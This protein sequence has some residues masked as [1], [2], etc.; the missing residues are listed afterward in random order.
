MNRTFALLFVAAALAGCQANAPTSDPFLRTRVP[1][2]GTGAAVPPGGAYYPNASYP[3]S[4]PSGSGSFPSTTP[5]STPAIP[6]S[7]PVVPPKDKFSPPGGF[8]LQ[9]SSVEP[10]KA[11]PSDA[12]EQ[13]SPPDQRPA[14]TLAIRRPATINPG[15]GLPIRDTAANELTMAAAETPEVIKWT[16]EMLATPTA[17]RA[18][19]QQPLSMPAT[20]TLAV[21]TAAGVAAA[22]ADRSVSAVAFRTTEPAPVVRTVQETAATSGPPRPAGAATIRILEPGSRPSEVALNTPRANKLDDR[23]DDNLDDDAD[24]DDD[25][26]ADADRGQTNLASPTRL[27]PKQL[28][29]AKVATVASPAATTQTPAATGPRYA[30]D[31]AYRWLSGMLEY[32]Q[33]ARQWKLRYIPIDG[34]TDQYGGSMILADSPSLQDF[35]PGD[36]VSIHGTISAKQPATRGF[37]P[38]YELSQIDRAAP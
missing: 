37:S 10:D 22:D 5:S 15:G 35:K 32:S 36:F 27:A 1:P 16:N 31:P 33:T 30:F 12:P 25:S 14:T 7:T 29:T 11:S 28:D 6:A 2:P 17:T 13:T 18:I 8:N 4:T 19:F 24:E 9:Q 26:Q 38:L 21:K 20:T 23:L 3:T 34:Q